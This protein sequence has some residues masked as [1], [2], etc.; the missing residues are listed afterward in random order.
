MAKPQLLS[1]AAGD[2]PAR[3]MD[4]MSRLYYLSRAIHIAA[5]LG[6]SDIIGSRSLTAADIAERD[7]LHG[8]SLERMLRYLSAY[9]VFR[10]GSDGTFRNSPLS[11]VLRHDSAKSIR[12]NLRRIGQAWWKAAGNLEHSI[13]TGES[14]FTDAN[15]LPFFDYLA[16]YPDQQARF[17]EGMAQI[18]DA[19]DAAIADAYD[20]SRF[21]KIVDVGGGRGGLLAQ[22]LARAP[23]A[24]GVLFDQHQVVNTTTRLHRA[25][26]LDRCELVGGDFFSSVAPGGDCYVIKGVLHDFS[27]DECVT[28]LSNMRQQI[29]ESGVVLVA[30]RILPFSGDGPHPNLTMDLQMMV[31]LS[32]RERTAESWSEIFGHAGLELVGVHDTSVDFSIVEGVPR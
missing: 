24:S 1:S 12:P 16:Q 13:R 9:G 8:P 17:D 2:D 10:E 20:F 3:I 26:L 28:I 4:E 21:A 7:G 15:G 14:A 22:I 25:G 29:P 6:L 27:D 18:S 11:D 23:A 30:D 32:G 5:E 31:L 19:D